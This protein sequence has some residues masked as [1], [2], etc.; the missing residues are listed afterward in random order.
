M[1]TTP[2]SNMQTLTPLTRA[3][4]NSTFHAFTC[5]ATSASHK[6][7]ILCSHLQ[8]RMPYLTIL[9][10]P[11][12]PITLVSFGPNSP[13]SSFGHLSMD[14][15]LIYSTTW[16]DP[17]GDITSLLPERRI[18][19]NHALPFPFPPPLPRSQTATCIAIEIC[20]DVQLGNIY[21]SKVSC[22]ASTLSHLCLQQHGTCLYSRPL[23]SDEGPYAIAAPQLACPLQP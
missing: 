17:Q 4:R 10:Y 23:S 19:G 12:E 2:C 11:F 14:H 9:L 13:E 7:G 5:H 20:Q 21:K 18:L 6:Y 16:L 1:T 8:L 3:G 22:E 15:L